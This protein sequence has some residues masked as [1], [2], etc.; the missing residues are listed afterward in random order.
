MNN[1]PLVA[2]LKALDIQYLD[3]IIPGRGEPFVDPTTGMTVIH[4]RREGVPG[5]F[6]IHAKVDYTAPWTNP[7]KELS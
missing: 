6:T 7:N 3:Q 1:S 4:Y 2:L 5:E